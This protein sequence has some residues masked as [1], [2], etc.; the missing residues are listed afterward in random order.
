VA[1][2]PESPTAW[3]LRSANSVQALVLLHVLC[4]WDLVQSSGTMLGL[5]LKSEYFYSGPAW[6]SFSILFFYISRRCKWRSNEIR[7]TLRYEQ[8]SK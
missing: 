3:A 6:M 2:V 7:A 1:I 4:C 8:R 5:V